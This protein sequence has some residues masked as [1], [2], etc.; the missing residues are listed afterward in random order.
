MNNV[1]QRAGLDD[2]D[3]V[4]FQTTD[5][6]CKY[7]HVE[8]APIPVSLIVMYSNGRDELRQRHK[9]GFDKPG[10]AESADFATPVLD[11]RVA[12]RCGT[13]RCEL[14]THRGG[15]VRTEAI[16]ARAGN[17]FL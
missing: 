2:A 14:S 9:R 3:S 4:G 8:A 13:W 12:C 1:S 15:S 6:F 7:I 11:V 5:P 10:E 16:P 17:L